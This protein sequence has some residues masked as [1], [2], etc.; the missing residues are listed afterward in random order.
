MSDSSRW[1]TKFWYTF[2]FFLKSYT[3]YFWS[4]GLYYLSNVISLVLVVWVWTLNS[5]ADGSEIVNFILIGNLYFSLTS[6]SYKWVIYRDILQGNLSSKLVRPTNIWLYYLAGTLAAGSRIVLVNTVSLVGVAILFRQ[7]LVWNWG[8]Q[9][10]W[11]IPFLLTSFLIKF[12]LDALTGVSA[13]WL[14]NAEGPIQIYEVTHTFLAGGVIPFGVLG[15]GYAWLQ[16]QPLA[17]TLLHPVKVILGE[18]SWQESLLFFIGSL[19]WG[20]LLW[21][22]LVQI[23]KWGLKRY[24][25]VG[26]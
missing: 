3:A 9:W 13:F 22:L 7:Y 1:L 14:T 24:E 10:L 26:M 20:L 4:D 12:S 5:R 11:I 21:W 2:W 6:Y 15:T 19:F 25:G 8:W 17:F 16:F 23:F 18:Y